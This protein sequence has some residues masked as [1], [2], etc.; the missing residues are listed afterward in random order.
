MKE[1]LSHFPYKLFAFG[2]RVKETN[3]KFSDLNLCYN[4]MCQ[5]NLGS[6]IFKIVLHG[7][8]FQREQ[9]L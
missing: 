1:I 8:T 3:R 2:S 7:N 4:G 9:S 5:I 6:I